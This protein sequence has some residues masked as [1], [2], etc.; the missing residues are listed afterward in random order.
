MINPL[1]V[2]GATLRDLFDEF[3]L[4][5][6]GN[7]IWMVLVGVPIWFSVVLAAAGAPVPGALVGLLTILPAGPATAGM[8]VIAQRVSEGRATKPADVWSGIRTYTRSFW[9]VLGIWI[10][11]FMLFSFNIGYYGGMPNIFGSAMLGLWLYCLI[12]WCGLLIYALPLVILQAQPGLRQIARTSAVM[13]FGHPV[14]TLATLVC[15]G[16]V[17]GLSIF[18]VAP[19][20]LFG[21]AW[22]ILWSFRAT[23]AVLAHMERRRADAQQSSVETEPQP[24]RGRKGQ[25]RPK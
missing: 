21:A 16:L 1:R 25:V 20:V 23:H 5:I 6:L 11:G 9:V 4:L 18:L 8:Y 3:L 24:E 10:T 14:F 15:M 2:L 19:I 12:L 7:M 13:A 17:L 22:L